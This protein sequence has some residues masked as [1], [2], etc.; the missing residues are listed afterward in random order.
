MIRLF[1]NFYN[2]DNNSNLPFVLKK[3]DLVFYGGS[4]LYFEKEENDYFIFSDSKYG[5]K[6]VKIKQ[7]K[8][9]E[10]GKY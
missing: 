2:N 6:Q 1:N 4:I 3:G 10:N 7:D 8:I 9:R 5:N